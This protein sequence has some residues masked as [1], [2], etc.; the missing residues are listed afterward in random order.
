MSRCLGTR[1]VLSVVAL[2]LTSS[3]AWFAMRALSGSMPQVTES[4]SET[5]DQEALVAGA[6]PDAPRSP[7]DPLE[8]RFSREVRPFLERYCISCHGAKKPKGKL[9]LSRDSTVEAIA[10]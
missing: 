1:L 7:H 8:H 5:E 10:K 4:D 6:N 3:G 2:C 9:D